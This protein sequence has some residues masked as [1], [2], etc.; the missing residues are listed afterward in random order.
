M[1]FLTFLALGPLFIAL[2]FLVRNSFVYKERSRILREDVNKYV[3]LPSY[4]TM[5]FQVWRWCY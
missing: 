2:F 3:N 1:I 5:L 4:N